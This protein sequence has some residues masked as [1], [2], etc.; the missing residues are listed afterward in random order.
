MQNLQ[1][2]NCL[3][4]RD[5]RTDRLLAF[6]DLLDDDRG[7]E[8]SDSWFEKGWLDVKLKD[9]EKKDMIKLFGGFKLKD[10][11]ILRPKGSRNVSEE[12]RL[13]RKKFLE[14]PAGQQMLFMK[15]ADVAMAGADA[16]VPMP[17]AVDTDHLHEQNMIDA[18]KP[19]DGVSKR[20]PLFDSTMSDDNGTLAETHEV[21]MLT[22]QMS[23]PQSI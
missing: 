1:F 13:D 19:D 3:F 6:L 4:E 12:F 8:A 5:L 22:P 15:G 23:E 16:N 17:S 21:E 9:Q 10:S 14:L 2:V 7:I 11:I 20:S 18:C